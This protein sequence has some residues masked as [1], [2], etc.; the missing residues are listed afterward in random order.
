MPLG[1]NVIRNIIQDPIIIFIFS[2][3]SS[4]SSHR[5]R[6]RRRRRRI[7]KPTFVDTRIEIFY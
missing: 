6:R 5:L 2:S 1:I 3:S 4:S 7:L